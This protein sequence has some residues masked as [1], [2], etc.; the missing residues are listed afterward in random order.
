MITK[1]KTNASFYLFAER[2]NANEDF[3]THGSL[4]GRAGPP[5]S[6]GQLPE[7][8]R[9]DAEQADYV[10]YSY[11]TPIAWKN[12]KTGRWTAPG[13]KYSTTTSRHQSKIATAVD[14]I[15]GDV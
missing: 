5:G 2:M 3:D 7:D 1:M 10:V 8:Y 9:E 6:F 15:N 11:N 4:R 12:A 14:V 13:T